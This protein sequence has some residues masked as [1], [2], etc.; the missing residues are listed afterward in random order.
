MCRRNCWVI[1]RRGE[2][3]PPTAALQSNPIHFSKPGDTWMQDTHHMPQHCLTPL[4]PSPH[5]QVL[6]SSTKPTAPAPDWVKSP[7]GPPS[8]SPCDLALACSS[9]PCSL[10][11]SIP[12]PHRLAH[13]STAADH[14][15]QH[16]ASPIPSRDPRSP[17]GHSVFILLFKH[18]KQKHI[19]FMSG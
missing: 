18:C 9:R 3:G 2:H 19:I 5:Q 1:T 12:A 13:A 16:A 4:G 6:I 14:M 10:S 11:P 17:S 7:A 15:D 8:T